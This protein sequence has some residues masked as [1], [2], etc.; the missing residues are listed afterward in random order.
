MEI[1]S[2]TYKVI[3]GKA[4]V[5]KSTFIKT[6]YSDIRWI[7]LS[8]TGIAAA[9]IDGSTINSFFNLGYKGDVDTKESIDKMNE[10]KR[11]TLRSALGLIIDEYYTCKKSIVIKINKILKI[12]R[13]SSKSFGGM[14][15][16]LFGDDRQTKAIGTSFID[17]KLYKKN[18]IEPLVVLPAHDKMRLTMDYSK[19]TDA[20][21]DPDISYKKLFKLLKDPRFPKSPIDNVET[22]YY[23]NEE[24]NKHNDRALDEFKGDEINIKFRTSSNCS[25]QVFKIGCPVRL[26]S[27]NCGLYNGT[28]ATLVNYDDIKKNVTLSIIKN[29]I[30]NTVVVNTCVMSFRLAFALTIHTSQCKTLTG[31]NIIM[32]KF[33][34]KFNKDDSIRLIYTAMTRV[35]SFE[36]CYIKI[37]K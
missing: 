23:T 32:N 17:S 4:G 5:G 28:L 2:P 10:V 18:F 30:T 22:V 33:V 1:D 8:F 13:N 26:E 21:R 11:D 31:I 15:V 3:I 24:V 34:F 27:N 29:N 37:I 25:N 16:I 6:Y 19:F 36:N 14:S 12:L 20:F 7:K 9:E 35:R